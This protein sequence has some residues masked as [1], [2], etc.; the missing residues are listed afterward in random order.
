MQQMDPYKVFIT[1]NS[2]T[3]YHPII[4]LLNSSSFYSYPH[5]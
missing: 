5:H 2:Y 3:F 1:S 4:L